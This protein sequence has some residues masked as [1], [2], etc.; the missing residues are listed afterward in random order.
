MPGAC[1]LPSVWPGGLQSGHK[2]LSAAL[3]GDRNRLVPKALGLAHDK[4][5]RGWVMQIL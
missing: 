5:S 2:K 3:S 4:P 1:L